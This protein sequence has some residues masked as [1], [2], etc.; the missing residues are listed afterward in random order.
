MFGVPLDGPANVHCDNE[1]LVKSTTRPESTLKKRHLSI[2][3]H[4]IREACAGIEPTICVAHES[5]L[6]NV[7]DLLTKFLCGK[8]KKDL[9]SWVLW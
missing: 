7:S 5:T 8:K 4:R 9:A 2:A 6:T 3:W 1:A